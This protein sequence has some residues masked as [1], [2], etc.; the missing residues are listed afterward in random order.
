MKR[1]KVY[2]CGKVA[3]ALCDADSLTPA[4]Q[5][6]AVLRDESA[7]CSAPLCESCRTVVGRRFFCGRGV[8]SSAPGADTVDLCPAHAPAPAL[9][10]APRGGR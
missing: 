3:V 9:R 7:T 8:Y 1:T 2:V 6:A 5:R 4:E 10:V